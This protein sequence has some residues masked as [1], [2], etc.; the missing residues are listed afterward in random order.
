MRGFLKIVE[1][2]DVQNI[3]LGVVDLRK[4]LSGKREE[5]RGKICGRTFAANQLAV[6]VRI[7]KLHSSQTDEN[8]FRGQKQQQNHRFAVRI[9][10]LL[11]A[12]K[13]R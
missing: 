10:Y 9:Q 6:I 1:I 4:E 3:T 12:Q 2:T 13:V 11:L 7:S 8:G 5:E